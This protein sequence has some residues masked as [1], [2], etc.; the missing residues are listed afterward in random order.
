MIAHPEVVIANQ[1]IEGIVHTNQ[2]IVA[3][4]ARQNLPKCHPDVFDRDPT[5]FH[6]WKRSFQ[7]MTQ[8][9]SLSPSQEIAYLQNY[10]KGKVQ[11]LFD[12]FRM[13]NSKCTWVCQGRPGGLSCSKILLVDVFV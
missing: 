13:L 8:D 10:T 12:H 1:C 7:A 2:Q 11:D 6:P 9:A 5:L 4:L 3:N